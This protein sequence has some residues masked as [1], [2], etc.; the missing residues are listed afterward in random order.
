MFAL[1]NMG[2]RIPKKYAPGSMSRRERQ[3]QMKAIRKSRKAYKKGKYVDRPKFASAKTRRSKHIN[4]VAKLY[5]LD[6][7]KLTVGKLARA[8]KC[9]RKALGKILSK[10]RGAFYSSGSRPN[11]TA[12]SW[13]KARLYS[14]LSGGPA[15]KIDRH[16]MEEGCKKN[17]KAL[18]LARQ[19]G[20]GR[21]GKTQKMKERIVGMERS[22]AKGKKYTATVRNIETGK[23]RRI[24]FGG[25]GY[26]QYKDRTKVGAFS[27]LDH[28]DRARMG[29]YFLRHSGTRVRKDAIAK[30]KS[31]SHGL[32]T[33]KILSHI[34]LW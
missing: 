13:A 32:Y 30:E 29:R 19:A 23:I 8:S 1:S 2:A 24:H 26:P 21:E 22:K 27:H 12:E 18:R 15:A 31:Q 3:L 20:G 10:G 11:Q 28:G 9:T 7:N 16:I 33:P 17:S 4:R 5:G 14:A 6:P 34:L 25:L